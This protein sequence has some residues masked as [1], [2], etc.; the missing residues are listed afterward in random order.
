[1]SA[2]PTDRIRNVVFVGQAGA[3]KTSLIEGLLQHAGRIG[4]AG[5]IERGNTV[6]D[7]DPL[8]QRY[9]HSINAS[10]LSIDVDEHRLNLIDTPGYADFLGV[11]LSVLDAADLVL[12]VVSAQSGIEPMTRDLV[13]QA[14][15]LHLP[16]MIVASKIDADPDRLEALLG[17]IGDSFGQ[18][19]LPIELP[20]RQGE[21]VVDVLENEHGEVDFD[22]AEHAHA[23]L[24][25]QIIETDDAVME[26]YLEDGEVDAGSLHDTLE[27]ALRENH[28]VP[29]AFASARSGAGLAE[30]LHLI[31]A[32]APNPLEEG[33]HPFITEDGSEVPVS[34]S[35]EEPLL[36]H[37]FRVEFDPYVGRI[38]L[39]RVHQGCLRRGATLIRNDGQELRVA[40]AYRRCG[41][42]QVEVDE[43]GPG[44]ICA[45]NKIDELELG[46]VLHA[47]QAH[48]GWRVRKP[49]LPVPLV[50]AALLPQARGD[51]QKLSEALHKLL[52][53]DPCLRIEHDAGSNEIV[54]RGLGDFHIKTTL[55]KLASRYRIEV[56]TRPPSVPYRETISRP[57]AAQYRHKKQTGGAGQFGE[58]HLT[59]EPLPRGAGFEFV[60]QVKGGVI[61]GQFIPAVE[62][63]V[64][65]AMEQGVVA[66]FPMQD[67][68][69][70]VVDGKHHSVDSKEIAF[71][72]AGR[73]AFEAA[74]RDAGPVVLEPIVAVSVTAPADSVG[75]ITG[76]LA[77]RRARI[78]GSDMAGSGLMRVNAELPLAETEGYA[79][80]L[81]A[82]TGGAGSW[83]LRFSHYDPVPARLQEELAAAHS[84]VEE[85]Q[86]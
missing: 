34:P 67:L 20:S 52:A 55:D 53:E 73:R 36:A 38:A 10:L 8:E 78:N 2:F 15:R 13:E 44:D 57:A 19:C 16:C 80:R 83:T 51:E 84:T 48:N 3:G 9:G 59:V 82:L 68:R 40:H 23:A 33:G 12:V 21:G 75:A 81:D 14:R 41:K 24:L 37:V 79:S 7:F 11:T 71:V 58:V 25:D 63:G 61:P 43:V 39:L 18:E 65:Q 85:A 50:G 70:T 62:K 17:E 72:A 56:D 77:T 26:R 42:E 30:L 74:V 86:A 46:D 6:S 32:H 5:S 47:G 49:E 76:D 1:M 66:G 4:T 60:D 27:R 28:L 54:L 31:V 29:V 64:R 69:V 35:L 45:V 22:S